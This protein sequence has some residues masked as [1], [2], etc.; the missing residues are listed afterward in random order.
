MS[1]ESGE[2]GGPDPTYPQTW[3]IVLT[4]D[5]TMSYTGY[6]LTDTPVCARF[7]GTFPH[8]IPQTR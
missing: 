1:G 8:L 5:V 3:T 6:D 2:P 4:H 7:V